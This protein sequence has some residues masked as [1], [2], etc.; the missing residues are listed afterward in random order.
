MHCSADERA[1]AR[2]DGA[3]GY[4]DEHN[5]IRLSRHQGDRRG[6]AAR[7]PAARLFR[8]FRR[9]DRTSPAAADVS[10]VDTRPAGQPAS[11]PVPTEP[12]H[13]P[14]WGKAGAEMSGA[15]LQVANPPEPK[16]DSNGYRISPKLPSS[17]PRYC[18]Q[19]KPR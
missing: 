5:P 14:A 18:V 6:R 3:R 2:G 17:F 9:H 15:V 13:G 1:S 8:G 10:M 19:P 7:Q 16:W 11:G 12:E 4:R